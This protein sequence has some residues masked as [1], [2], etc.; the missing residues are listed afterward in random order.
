[1]NGVRPAESLTLTNRT[2]LPPYD[3]VASKPMCRHGFYPKYVGT[4]PDGGNLASNYA[5]SAP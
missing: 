5:C 1:V 2:P 4:T 3:I